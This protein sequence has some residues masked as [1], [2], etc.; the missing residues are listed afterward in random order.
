ETRPFSEKQIA[1]VKTFAGQAAI[2]IENVRLFNETKEALEQQQ[3]SGQV[4]ATISSSIADTSPVFDKILE[5]CERLFAGKVIA[6]ELIDEADVIRVEAYRGPAPGEDIRV[7]GPV[8]PG[9]SVSANAILSGRV[10]HLPDIASGRNVPAFSRAGY[11]AIGVRAA[12]VAPML[13]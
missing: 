11:T 5:S 2:A 12:I 8:A 6:I 1:L 7:I 3:A 9:A 4:L 13:W 10:Q